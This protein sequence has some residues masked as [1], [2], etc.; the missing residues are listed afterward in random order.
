MSSASTHFVQE[1]VFN[2]VEGNYNDHRRINVSYG[3]DPGPMERLE[4]HTSKG[5]A[6]DSAERG[7]DAPKCD[8]ETRV[9]VQ[10]DIIS[11]IQFGRHDPS[12]TNIL[13]LSGPAGAG[14][15][16]IM[17]SIADACYAN[18]WLAASFFFSAFVPSSPDRR[19]KSCLIP[20][21][22]YHLVQHTA[23]PGLKDLILAAVEDTPSVFDKGLDQQL[24]ILL[25]Q[26][27][28]RLG[29]S[30]SR[31]ID[32]ETNVFVIAIDGIDECDADLAGSFN[33][34]QERRRSRESNHREILSVLARASKD[35]SFPFR[36]VIAS[37][38]ERTFQEFFSTRPGLATEMF[39]DDKYDPDSDIERYLNSK[40]NAIRRKFGLPTSWVS[41]EDIL[42]LV[43]SASGQ[44]IYAATVVRYL[45]DDT[46]PP[47]PPKRLR[48]VLAWR[49]DSIGSNPFAPLD[50]LY[51]GIL[52]TNPD[53][54]LAV[55]WL[56]CIHL[57]S[58]WHEYMDYEDPV[59]AW[60]PACIRQL[61]ESYAGEAEFVL[62]GL[63]SL[64][65]LVDNRGRPTFTFHHK[66][67]LDFLKSAERSG[68]LYIDH[69]DLAAFVQDRFYAVVK[70]AP[71]QLYLIA[72]SYT[73]FRVDKG[74][75]G[76]T[77]NNPI[78]TFTFCLRLPYQIDPRRLYQ[79]DDVEW[80]LV[81]SNGILIDQPCQ[82]MFANVHRQVCNLDHLYLPPPRVHL[83]LKRP[84][85]VTGTVASQ[86]VKSGGREYYTT[87]KW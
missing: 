42:R 81:Q 59:P 7:P 22:A 72:R 48:Q 34:E 14:K 8:P 24:D 82:I 11:W 44:F 38:P 75:L 17:G 51:R 83:P 67:F 28:R 71:V 40:F 87:A 32:G 15:T 64:V 6:H 35:P 73:H 68:S 43:A 57:A 63:R 50:A 85:S 20:T 4:R 60:S 9:A 47:S 31:G 55:R 33:S 58:T 52:E 19:S 26:P 36:I 53:T 13:R 76:A 5:A 77:R 80:W 65:G 2:H 69:G 16:A 23:F 56:L 79:A 30:T 86:L 3:G 41:Q 61:L 1:A 29:T 78:F 12:P 18:G 21:L 74:S 39:L 46:K 37:R 49:E 45:E 62:G 25:L 27:F 54:T 70:S 66:S 84:I 10:Q